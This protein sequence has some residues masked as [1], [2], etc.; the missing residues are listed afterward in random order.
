MYGRISFI[1]KISKLGRPTGQWPISPFHRTHWYL[2]PRCPPWSQSPH[3]DRNHSSELAGTGR[4]RSPPPHV[5]ERPYPHV[6]VSPKEPLSIFVSPNNHT[7][8]P[9]T[10][11]SLPFPP[12]ILLAVTGR[13]KVAPSLPTPL[14]A[15]AAGCNARCEHLF[16]R[17]FFPNGPVDDSHAM[18]SSSPTD[19]TVSF[20][21]PPPNCYCPT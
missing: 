6:W 8:P 9:F 7:I 13:C 1:G 19:H 18:S 10:L 16:G 4:R 15:R 12:T 11:L 3:G 17:R 2:V 5:G 14:R 21:T 20:P